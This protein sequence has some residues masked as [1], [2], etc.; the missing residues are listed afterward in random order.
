MK[1]LTEPY[2][3]RRVGIGRCNWRN[4]P[5]DQIRAGIHKRAH[6]GF[7][8]VDTGQMANQWRGILNFFKQ[9]KGGKGEE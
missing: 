4:T 5:N 2:K 3:G 8:D 7:G 1:R 9:L 6:A